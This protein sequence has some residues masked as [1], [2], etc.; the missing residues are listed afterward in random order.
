MDASTVNFA[1]DKNRKK[2]A[3]LQLENIMLNYQDKMWQHEDY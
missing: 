1:T 3:Q 2:P